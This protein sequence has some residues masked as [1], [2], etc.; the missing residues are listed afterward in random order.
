MATGT[1]SGLLWGTGDFVSV[2]PGKAIVPR[3]YTRSLGKGE[4]LRGGSVR[5]DTKGKLIQVSCQ[6]DGMEEL[7][8]IKTAGSSGGISVNLSK[9][10]VRVKRMRSV[11][12]EHNGR[13]VREVRVMSE[14]REM[15]EHKQQGNV[16]VETSTQGEGLV[17]A[18]EDDQG[19]ILKRSLG[20]GCGYCESRDN[21]DKGGEGST[22]TNLDFKPVKSF[23][24]KTL[25]DPRKAV[26]VVANLVRG[27]RS[28][29]EPGRRSSRVEKN[30]REG[31]RLERVLSTKNDASL[32]LRIFHTEGKGRGILTTR[33][34]VK[35]EPVVEYK[36]TLLPVEEAR[37]KQENG[38]DAT[39][40]FYSALEFGKSRPQGFCVDASW[41]SGRFGRLVNHSKKRPNCEVRVEMVKDEPHLILVAA[42][43]IGVGVEITYNYGIKDK[44]YVK[45]N[46]WLL[47]S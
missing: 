24:S 40:M 41:D 17:G 18:V 43:D 7:Q 37:A 5:H 6:L 23:P 47:S 2:S 3:R 10:D 16:P 46:P 21:W 32:G 42:E 44:E 14:G 45:A 25:G 26:A 35:G 15:K 12:R 13:E 20:D 22:G 8:S 1:S 33:R 30:G 28:Q 9:S 11:P 4:T 39:Y 19:V 27:A 29:T 31:L 38:E 36:G 34:F